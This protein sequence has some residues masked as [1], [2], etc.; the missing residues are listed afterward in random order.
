[1]EADRK[2]LRISVT[3]SMEMELD[4]IKKE[5]YNEDTQNDMICDLI[6]RGLASLKTPKRSETA[7]CPEAVRTEF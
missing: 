1:M 4:E 6:R 5:C 2:Q 7:P 3:Q